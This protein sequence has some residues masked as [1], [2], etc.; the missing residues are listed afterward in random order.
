MGRA[1]DMATDK[2]LIHE[3]GAGQPRNWDMLIPSCAVQYSRQ[4]LISHE[5]MR[6]LSSSSTP[7]IWCLADSGW[8]GGT[9]QT[10]GLSIGTTTL[11]AKWNLA[12]TKRAVFSGIPGWKTR[13]TDGAQKEAGL[14][15]RRIDMLEKS[16]RNWLISSGRGGI[17]FCSL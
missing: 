5:Q 7:H 15:P 6:R 3:V 17:C 1:T 2:Q 14:A 13:S 10:S 11:A 9:Q 4:P 12:L 16:R 8:S